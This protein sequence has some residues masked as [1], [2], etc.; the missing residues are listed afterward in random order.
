MRLN[1]SLLGRA[2]RTNG[3]RGFTLVELLVVIAIIAILMGLLL[4]AVQMAREAARRAQCGNNLRQLGLAAMNYES[5]RGNFPPV[6]NNNGVMWS[7]FLLPYLELGNIYDRL[8]IQDPIES[9]DFELAGDY[10]WN[11][12]NYGA[13]MNKP[14][15]MF[16]C[17]SSDAPNVASE[18]SHNG[19]S[20]AERAVSNYLAVGSARRTATDGSLMNVGLEDTSTYASDANSQAMFI[21]NSF[22]FDDNSGWTKNGNGTKGTRIAEFL[23]GTSNTVM[24]GEAVP[25]HLEAGSDEQISGQYRRKDHWAIA[26]DDADR[27]EDVSEFMGSMAVPLGLPKRLKIDPAALDPT[28][29]EYDQY[30]MAFNSNHT[31]LVQYLYADGSVSNI[32][33]DIDINTQNQIGTRKGK[34]VVNTDLLN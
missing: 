15:K 5:A 14:Q 13:L 19:E 7:G 11:D 17:P 10:V 4:P 26:S 27:F 25:D 23:D 32:S 9:P 34:E 22:K 3:K 24:I 6:V 2:T 28:N 16:L 33:V 21:A 1:E 29:A 30:E 20:F 31:G 8:V 18:L 12:A